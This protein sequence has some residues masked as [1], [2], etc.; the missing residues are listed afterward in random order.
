MT[1]DWT[2]DAERSN[3]ARSP[4][5]ADTMTWLDRLARASHDL[6]IGSFGTTPEGRDM[7]YVVAARDGD[8]TLEFAHRSGKTVLLVEAGIHSGEIEGKDAGLA[9]LR[10]LTVTGRWQELLAHTVLVFI[11]VFNIDGHERA[12]RWLRIN[13]NGPEE[14]GTRGTAQNLNLNR[15]FVK[16]DAPEMRAW[17]KLFGQWMPD[18]FVDIHTTNGADYAYDL[19]WFLEEWHSLHPAPRAWQQE[20][21]VGRV[22]PAMEKLGHRLAPYLELVDHRDITK[23]LA[24]FGSGPRYSTGYT[25]IRNRPGLLVETHMLKSYENRVHS[26]YDLLVE[27]LRELDANPGALCRAVDVADRETV[28]HAGDA[29]SRLALAHETTK[30]SEP[31]ELDGYAFT[32]EASEISG[33]TWTTYQPGTPLRATVPFFRQLEVVDAVDRPA[34]YAVPAAWVGHVRACLDAHGIGSFE[35]RAPARVAAGRYRLSAARFASASFEGRVRLEHFELARE[36]GEFELRAGSLIVRLDQP[37]ANVAM[38]LLEPRGPDSLLQWGAFNA[39][40]ESR[41][42]A[43]AR[44]GET[45]AREMLREDP[46]LRAAFDRELEDPGFASSPER[47]L[48]WFFDRSPW[49]DPELGIYPVLRL[50]RATY[51]TLAAQLVQ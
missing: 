34:A 26:T 42:Y 4:S 23:G 51:A 11:P 18:L 10:D 8:T 27:I 29:S 22:F 39:I 9:L 37:A 40:F 41:E 33:D 47:R 44:V 32:Q 5:Y 30:T 38:H 31:F 2:T 3:Y 43:D 49:L 36:R 21:L 28:A 25:A 16:A 20:A 48:R 19:T 46:A 35:L 45:L 50:D 14:R 12:S 24:N 1:A 13:Q 7:R 6:A 15:D 17:L